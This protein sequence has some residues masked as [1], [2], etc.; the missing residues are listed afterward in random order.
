MKLSCGSNLKNARPRVGSNPFA[1][2]AQH[3]PRRLATQGPGSR[4]LPMPESQWFYIVIPRASAGPGKK[5]KQNKRTG[6]VLLRRR[7][8]ARS[9]VV[10]CGSPTPFRQPLAARGGV[11]LVVAN[12]N[13]LL[14]EDVFI[15][16]PGRPAAALRH[17]VVHTVAFAGA[18]GR[19]RCCRRM[20]PTGG[21]SRRWRGRRSS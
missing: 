7:A 8:A 20:C 4:A 12:P 6:Q 19:R 16:Y 5:N 17:G 21:S 2:R 13:P 10:G 18:G 15:E 14:L 11:V 9:R 1:A 3:I